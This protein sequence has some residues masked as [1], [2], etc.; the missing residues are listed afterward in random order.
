[1]D[2][3]TRRS[4]G[5]RRLTRPRRHD[6]NGSVDGELASLEKDVLACGYRPAG[7]SII[8]PLVQ[9]ICTFDD[10]SS[11]LIVAF[12]ESRDPAADAGRAAID[13]SPIPRFAP[14]H[15]FILATTSLTEPVAANWPSI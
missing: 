11:V 3:A 9:T 15:R 13:A 14:Y 7:Y 2:T 6:V 8:R 10:F 12:R 4:A 1:M 5:R